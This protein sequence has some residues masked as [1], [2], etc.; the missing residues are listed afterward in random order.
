[1]NRK[2]VGGVLALVLAAVAIW[3]LFVRDRGGSPPSPGADVRKPDIP[4]GSARP[5][6]PAQPEREGPRGGRVQFELDVDPEGPLPLEGQVLGP[7]GK[8]IAGAEVRLDSNPPRTTKSEDDGT[9]QFT[10]LVGRTYALTATSGTLIGTVIYKLTD[11]SDPAVIRLS[12]G[13]KLVVTVTDA[14]TKAPIANATVR[15]EAREPAAKTDASGE[16]TLAPL[17]P[18]W[19]AAQAV[20]DGYA[21]NTAFTT[22]GSGG[23]TGKLAIALRK[24]YPV[25]GRVVDDKGKPIAKARVSFQGGAE[26]GLGID[27][28]DDRADNITDAKGRFTIPAVA[29]GEHT[30][31][32]VDGEHEPARERI[33][34]ADRALTDL[35]IVMKPGGRIAGKVVDASKQPVPFATV[36]V[37]GADDQMFTVG[38]RQTTTD[39]QGVFELRGLSRTKLAMRAESDVAASTVTTVDL[40]ATAEQ[41]NLEL[42]LDQ[43]GSIAG[44]VVDETG[45]A[46]AEVT[47]HA[48]PDFTSGS[49]P[50][51]ALAFSSLSTATTDGAG[52]FAIRGLPQGAWRLDA[53]RSST[54]G[55]RWG[56]GRTQA[57][58]GDTNVRL[59]LATPG[60]IK[61][62][63]V[64]AGAS[65]P[66]ALAMVQLGWQPPTPAFDGTFDIRDVEPGV[67]HLTIRGPSFTDHEQKVEVEAGKVL[68]L[69]TL[70][71]QR[72][73]RLIGKV[74]DA[75]GSPVPDARVRLGEWLVTLEG[76]QADAFEN[77]EQQQGIRATKTGQDGTFELVGIP[78]KATHAMAS[79]P[80]LGSSQSITVPAGT[81]DPPATTITLRG[82]GSIAGTVTSK[83]KPAAGVTITLSS[84]EGGTQLSFAQTDEKGAF[85]LTKVAEGSYVVQAMQADRF[86][87]SMRNTS[88]EATVSAGKP[89]K[90]D[91]DIPVG[92]IALTV[93]LEPLPGAS[94]DLA[95]VFLYGGAVA[96]ANGKQIMDSFTAGAAKG[97]KLW[98]G[99]DA[100]MPEFTELVPGDYSVCAIPI[101][102]SITDVELQR[103]LQENMDKLKVYCKAVKVSASPQKQT[104]VHPL[105]SME[106][107]P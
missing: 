102:G 63:L 84:K 25:S 3:L 10:K 20:A 81:D 26:W 89:T 33:T 98:L 4:A 34:V 9:F 54:V 38:A 31:Y 94:F 52:G 86:G 58:T 75:S 27:D 39:K 92:N 82:F 44:T 83:G 67:H 79:H 60:G 8:A 16:A 7:D 53:V 99:K 13:V 93:K 96:Y 51:D 59:V 103:K 50:Q 29:A 71:L 57:K 88:A 6:D 55:M 78:Q 105:P 12:E 104:V 72:G 107:I 100:P 41:T 24:G 40:G 14:T 91:I 70:T 66:P 101:T 36:R 28:R 49:P 69:G 23:A 37:A 43:T 65:Q 73:R 19:V 76:E 35:E 21:P 90:V 85:K 62:K 1:M 32:A 18:G 5:A 48:Y 77:I 95:Q 47:V 22:V 15:G 45:A 17:A 80:T 46:V 42:V 56:Q 74:V 2:L 97:M 11:Q 68:E 106:P 30:L 61:G 64:I 87:T